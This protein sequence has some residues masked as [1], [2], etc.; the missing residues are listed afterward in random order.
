MR[1]RD[2][3]APPRRARW[4]GALVALA[5]GASATAVAEPVLHEFI[6]L[7][8][9]DGPIEPA[10]T[11]QLGAPQRDAPG[12]GA[13]GAADDAAGGPGA[14]GADS[15]LSIDNNTSRPQRVSY[16][17]PFTP[18]VVPF[19]RGMV[20]D[21][22]TRDGDLIVRNHDLSDV[23][24]LTGPRAND[25]HFHAV[26]EL[27]LTAGER[28]PI[29]SVAPGARL[30]LVNRQ[31]RV[32]LRIGIDS[33]ENWFVTSQ[34]SRHVQLNL[35]IVADRR[36]FGSDFPDPSPSQLA[37]ALPPLPPEVKQA[38]LEVARALGVDDSARPQQMVAALVAHFRRFSASDRRPTSQGLAL[39]RELALTAR[40]ICRHR[41]Y[42][43]MLTALG[44][45]IPTRLALNEA[46][47]WV[48][49]FDGELWH[50]IDLGGAAD[51]LE[52]DDEG[53]PRHVEPRDPF[54][55]PDQRESGL[56]MAERRVPTDGAPVPDGTG[57]APAGDPG[58]NGDREPNEATPPPDEPTPG[59]PGG[60]PPATND[61]APTPPPA[62]P[63]A[64]GD[65]HFS[66]GPA[67]AERGRSLYVSG[68]VEA[69]GHICSGARVDVVLGV[70]GSGALAIGSLMSDSRGEFGGNLVIPWNATL[71]QHTL[72]A[73][74]AGC[75][76]RGIGTR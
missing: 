17:D 66:M 9:G 54:S 58:S 45:G 37:R 11:G 13:P 44:L 64:P 76:P 50:R 33:A 43:F 30:V 68:R 2:P 5:L 26:F 40:G 65:V 55:W 52:V 31:P 72:S 67:R 1:R 60:T 39:Y 49:V 71:G 69:G 4:V 24:A 74:A 62:A 35:Q 27:D 16:S 8:P 29:P 22:V 75:M 21:G 28:T 57:G 7:G 73:T 14:P 3:T 10:V 32:P 25:E 53:R 41:S 61:P 15:S 51:E 18:T 36:V 12:P 38:A 46:H 70:P 47:A 34:S 6:E 48:E 63:V 20:F 42:A 19:K 59:Q 56:A 23:P